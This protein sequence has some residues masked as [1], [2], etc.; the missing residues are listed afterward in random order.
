M[1]DTT[2]TPKPPDAAATDQQKP[3]TGGRI[4]WKMDFTQDDEPSPVSAVDDSTLPPLSD[5]MRAMLD[6]PENRGRFAPTTPADLKE[7]ATNG[8]RDQ[9][10]SDAGTGG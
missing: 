4:L 9:Q 10:T 6:D 1:P 5:E 8:K 2:E 7:T 3:S